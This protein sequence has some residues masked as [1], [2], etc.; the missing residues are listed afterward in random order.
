MLNC[1]SSSQDWGA[2]NESRP[3]EMSYG[4][5]C[6]KISKHIQL[7]RSQLRHVNFFKSFME[8]K[9]KKTQI[10]TEQDV[11]HR[12]YYRRNDNQNNIKKSNPT[13]QNGYPQRSTDSKS[14]R[15]PGHHWTPLHSWWG[16]T[17]PP[18]LEKTASSCQKINH[19]REQSLVSDIHA[20]AYVPEKTV[21]QKD[22]CTPTF[23]VVF[24]TEAK[25][26]NHKMSSDRI[27]LIADVVHK[28]IRISQTHKSSTKIMKL[29]TASM[30]LGGSHTN[31]IQP[32]RKRIAYDV[33]SRQIKWYIQTNLQHKRDSKNLKGNKELP[34]KKIARDELW[35]KD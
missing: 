9:G 12:N 26:Q 17:L 25:T 21:V 32:G 8:K 11:Q 29:C 19:W 35:I 15:E 14:R 4:G 18:P 34:G 3:Q 23:T 20:W 6:R 22:T 16:W 27:K 33:P 30:D 31:C 2:F 24:L 5:Y 1:K 7:S 28:C 13:S 10:A